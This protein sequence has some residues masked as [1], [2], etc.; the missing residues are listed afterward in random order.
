MKTANRHCRLLIAF[1]T[2]TSTG[3]AVAQTTPDAGQLLQQ[4][5]RKPALPPKALP[6]Q[7]AQPA[8]LQ[9]LTGVVINVTRFRLAGNT[10][11]GV[12]QLQ[13][14]LASFLNRTLDYSQLQAAAAAVAETYR[15]A[16][17][18]LS[19]IHI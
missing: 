3:L 17:W 16:G 8:A 7:P 14:A 6:T 19:L 5:E 12:E 9:P 15:A 18:I 2:I 11:L 1:A 4:L 13:P 10:L